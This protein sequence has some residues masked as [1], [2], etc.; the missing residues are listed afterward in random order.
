MRIFDHFHK[1]T[2]RKLPHPKI[3][4]MPRGVGDL[5]HNLRGFS[6]V[7][8]LEHWGKFF[9]G[10]LEGDVHAEQTLGRADVA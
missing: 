10:R 6:R 9:A 5:A 2:L 4:I 8:E 1:P 3:G 7:I